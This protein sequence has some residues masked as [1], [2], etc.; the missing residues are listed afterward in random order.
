MTQGLATLL[1]TQLQDD[2]V[3]TI[4]DNS[5]LGDARAGQRAAAAESCWR[6][7]AAQMG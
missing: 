4:S 5:V 7:P 6:R 3:D 2:G 1:L